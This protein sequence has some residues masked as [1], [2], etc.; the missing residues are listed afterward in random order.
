MREP[1]LDS[2][3]MN[4]SHSSLLA[5]SFCLNLSLAASETLGSS[6]WS[7]AGVTQ[8]ILSDNGALQAVKAS[9]S[10]GSGGRG[11]LHLRVTMP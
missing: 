5:C 10:A 11:F 4:L 8:Q 7:G 3:P 9:V 2:D 6:S 1:G